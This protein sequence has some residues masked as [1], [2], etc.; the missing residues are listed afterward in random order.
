MMPESCFLYLQSP[1]LLPAKTATQ[2]YCLQSTAAHLRFV[3]RSSMVYYAFTLTTDYTDSETSRR[4]STFYE[5]DLQQAIAVLLCCYTG[6]ESMHFPFNVPLFLKALKV[7][8]KYGI[9][10]FLVQLFERSPVLVVYKR[11]VYNGRA[12]IANARNLL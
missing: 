5:L 4:V 9:V 1:P 10:L 3:F 2:I 6:T 8:F 11:I 7:F 12:P